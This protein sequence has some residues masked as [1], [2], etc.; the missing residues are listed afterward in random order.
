MQTLAIKAT[1]F[2]PERR[3]YSEIIIRLCSGYVSVT[4]YI[5]NFRMSE[6]MMFVLVCNSLQPGITTSIDV[7]WHGLRYNACV[8]RLR[9][10]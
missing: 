9:L 10:H 2:N 7:K 4:D 3:I 5:L 8:C 6:A 1:S